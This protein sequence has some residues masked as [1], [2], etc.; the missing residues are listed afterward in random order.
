MDVI[1]ESNRLFVY[2]YIHLLKYQTSFPLFCTHSPILQ[3]MSSVDGG[4][5]G[6]STVSP[7][8]SFSMAHADIWG[9]PGVRGRQRVEGKENPLLIYVTV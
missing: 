9:N 2:P 4:L 5:F 8:C 6:V 1:T 7:F 3:Y